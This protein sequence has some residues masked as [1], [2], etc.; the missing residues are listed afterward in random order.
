LESTIN[1]E[2]PATIAEQTANPERARSNK[3]TGIAERAKDIESTEMLE[4]SNERAATRPAPS[5]TSITLYGA[6]LAGANASRPSRGCSAIC[7]APDL[8]IKLPEPFEIQAIYSDHR[9]GN[10]H[11][12]NSLVTQFRRVQ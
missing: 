3:R 7:S 8:T 1:A 10:G 9:A 12:P 2:R 5:I 11:H 6:I 4:R